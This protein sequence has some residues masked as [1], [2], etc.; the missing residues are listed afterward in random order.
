MRG[1]RVAKGVKVGIGIRAFGWL[2]WKWKKKHLPVARCT[3][4]GQEVYNG[5]RHT[6]SV[7]KTLVQTRFN[8]RTQTRVVTPL[9]LHSR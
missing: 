7:I 9:Q 6:F 1:E 4:H 3:S 5:P 8:S 2:V